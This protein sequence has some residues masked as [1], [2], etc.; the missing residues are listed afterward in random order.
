MRPGG[1]HK[2]SSFIGSI[3]T[4]MKGLSLEEYIQEAYKGI[5]NMLNGKN[6]SR[7]VPGFHM[8]SSG[9][10]LRAMIDDLHLEDTAKFVDAMT[11]TL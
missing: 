10:V 1:M 8:M 11:S 6:W 2:L 5:Q 4:I 7:A 9:L 3:G